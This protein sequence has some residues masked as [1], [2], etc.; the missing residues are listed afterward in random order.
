MSKSYYLPSTDEGKV[1]WLN[2]FSQK[3]QD[4]NA[5]LGISQAQMTSIQND[6]T[7][8]SYIV[9][10]VNGFRNGL[11]ERVGYKDILK[12]GADGAPLSPVPVFNNNP[13][14]TVVPAGIFRRV[15]KLVQNIKS[16]PNYNDSIGGNLGIIGS[17]RDSEI[18]D[19]KPA[20]KIKLDAGKPTI[21]WKKGKA[22]SLDIY[23]DRGD[24]KGFGYLANDSSPDFTDTT[25]LNDTDKIVEWKYKAIYRIKDEQVG[26]FSDEVSVMVKK[27]I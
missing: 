9:N 27:E 3:L 23:V 19:L 10:L 1:T 13:A 17:E 14:P 7:M 6:A 2:N 25:I 21:I 24:N 12:N 22:D 5:T 8:F 4:H 11:S 18:L 16:N 20:I 26:S 15:A